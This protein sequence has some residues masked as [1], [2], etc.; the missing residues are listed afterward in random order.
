MK[1]INAE[2]R[3]VRRRY[4]LKQNNH[5]Q[6]PRFSIFRSVKHMSVQII[7]DKVGRTL[8]SC[9]S[10]EKSMNIKGY[11][12]AGAKVIGENIAKRALEKNI[13]SVVFDIGPY[14]YHGKVKAIIET[15]IEKGL[16]ANRAKG[17]N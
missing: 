10:L 17:V 5:G 14:K 9:S 12:I 16:N 1:N 7:D 6:L 2:R 8:V 11:N 4:H 13:N 15:A 3:K